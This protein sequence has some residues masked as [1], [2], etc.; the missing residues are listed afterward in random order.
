[1]GTPARVSAL[2]GEC[3]VRDHHRCVVSRKFDLQEAEKRFAL[4]EPGK[5]AKDDEEGLL[6]EQFEF[7]SLEVAHILPHSLMRVNSNYELVSLVSML[8]L[9]LFIAN[10]VFRILLEKLHLESLT[11]SIMELYI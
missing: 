6:H 8:L 1:M 4:E 5:L 10:L 9:S 2:R 11:C 7:A 3:L